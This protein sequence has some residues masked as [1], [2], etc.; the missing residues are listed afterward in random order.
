MKF[1]R[2]LNSW[3]ELGPITE[4]VFFR[5]AIVPSQVFRI[6]CILTQIPKTANYAYAICNQITIFYNISVCGCHWSNDIKTKCEWISILERIV[7]CM[8][9]FLSCLTIKRYQAQ[10]RRLHD[11]LM[12]ESIWNSLTLH[13]VTKWFHFG[14]N[15]PN[16]IVFLPAF[17]VQKAIKTLWI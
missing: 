5:H 16:G 10:N 2:R 1:G 17:T 12:N 13:A 9:R 14:Y 7:F 3:E 8:P 11:P 6:A 4:Y 15:W